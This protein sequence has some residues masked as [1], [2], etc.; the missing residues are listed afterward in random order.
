MVEVRGQNVMEWSCSPLAKYC[1]APWV[2][3]S[4]RNLVRYSFTRAYLSLKLQK[5]NI[6]SRH[7]D[8]Y[9]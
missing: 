9:R 6:G 7:V 2:A 8:T 5:L 4:L 1:S 3:D